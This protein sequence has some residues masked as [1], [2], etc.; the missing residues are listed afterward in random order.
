MVNAFDD[1]LPLSKQ[2]AGNQSIANL[3]MFDRAKFIECLAGMISESVSNDG[4]LVVSLEGPWGFGKTSAK[5]MLAEALQNRWHEKRADEKGCYPRLITVEFDPWLFSGSNDVVALMFSSI[6]NA[7]DE[8]LA[9]KQD[10]QASMAAKVD[11]AKRVADIADNIDKT[12][13]L[14]AI[15]GSLKWVSESMTP[16]NNNT[17]PL[18]QSRNELIRQLRLLPNDYAIVVYIDEIDRLDDSDIAALFKALKSVGNLPRVVYVP[19]FDREII[20]AALGRVSQQGKG[21]QYLEKIVQI[22]ITLPQIPSEV[23]WKDFISQIDTL[24]SA[25]S[26]EA[27]SQQDRYSLLESCVSPFVKSARDEHRILNAFRIAAWQ[28]SNEVNLAELL[29]LTVLQLYDHDFYDWIYWHHD[30]LLSSSNKDDAEERHEDAKERD[31]Y[32]DS[33]LSNMPFHDRDP[34]TDVIQHR[35]R[36]LRMLFPAYAQTNYDARFIYVG[37]RPENNHLVR[38]GSRRVSDPQCFAT[39]FRLALLDQN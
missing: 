35:S 3:D 5:N 34:S 25:S 10:K 33:E 17:K 4:S 37:S 6:I 21:S 39:Y 12:G 32:V 27:I 9:A 28:L 18:I 8:D 2:K 20:A 19:I 15:S 22:P 30:V 31:K 7:I 13:F 14:K 36:I 16:E 11:T 23:V 38:E 26:F 24:T 29:C 1:D